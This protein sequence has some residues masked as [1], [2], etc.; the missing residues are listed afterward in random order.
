[1]SDT[2]PLRRDIGARP[3]RRGVRPGLLRARAAA[4]WAD[5]GLRTWRTWDAGGLIPRPLRVGGCVLWSLSEL[6]SWR[7]A[8]CPRRAEWEAQRNGRPR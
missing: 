7:D 1:M 8:G 2:P 3:R 5:V 4:A 6:R